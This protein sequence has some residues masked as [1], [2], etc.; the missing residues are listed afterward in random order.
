[1]RRKLNEQAATTIRQSPKSCTE[2]AQ[3]FNV[4]VN[5]ISLVRA[6]KTFKTVAQT[7]PLNTRFR[8][9]TAPHGA[10]HPRAKLTDAQ[11]L[12]I[13][14]SPEDARTV[15]KTYDIALAQVYNIRRGTSWRHLPSRDEL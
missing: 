6:G 1:M 13:K 2:L 3:Q 10:A 11:A 5:C 9:R 4:S 14:R 12:E 7:I 15:A 8:I